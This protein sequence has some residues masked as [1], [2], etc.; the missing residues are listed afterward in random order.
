MLA[1]HVATFAT[2]TASSDGRFFIEIALNDGLNVAQVGL[3]IL[4]AN[5]VFGDGYKPL[6]GGNL[7]KWIFSYSAL[8]GANFLAL[9]D[10]L[11]Q[12]EQ[13]LDDATFHDWL[14]DN[15]VSLALCLVGLAVVAA[16]T[17]LIPEQPS[18][19]RA[20]ADAGVGIATLVAFTLFWLARLAT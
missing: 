18:S 12:R 19:P 1:H 15:L 8:V 16:C 13:G 14:T 2:S 7:G 4:A 6:E 17:K 10:T 20:P 11:V 9:L 3:L 5:R